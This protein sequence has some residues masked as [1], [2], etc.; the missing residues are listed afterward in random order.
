MPLMPQCRPMPAGSVHPLS[1][2]F[3]I[4]SPP[5]PHKSETGKSRG[6]F[7][8]HQITVE[9]GTILCSVPPTTQRKSALSAKG[10]AT[11]QTPA[12]SLE[13]LS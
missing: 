11:I 2:L 9:L 4:L 10:L 5:S 8:G 7:L 12:N 3:E 6:L 13:V 1:I